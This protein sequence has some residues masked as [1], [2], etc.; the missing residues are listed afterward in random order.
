M[1]VSDWLTT[2]PSSVTEWPRT[3]G[4]IIGPHPSSTCSK[5]ASK[6][7]NGCKVSF[8]SNQRVCAEDPQNVLVV[9]CNAGKGRTGTSLCAIMLYVGLFEKPEDC[10]R[11]FNW[12]RFRQGSGGVSQPCQVRSLYY[13]DY[14]L[15]QKSYLPTRKLLRTIKI[16]GLP[17]SKS[18]S[19]TE[20][21]V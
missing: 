19:T 16:T 21:I 20:I 14:V 4:R 1:W 11:L 10:V 9:H 7:S 3:T 8:Q 15:N 2:P 12:K 18:C 6:L 17:R 13:F 5:S